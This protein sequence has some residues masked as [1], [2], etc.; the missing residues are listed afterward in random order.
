MV[1]TALCAFANPTSPYAFTATFGQ[2]LSR[3]CR[4][5]SL[6]VGVRGSS[7]SKSML[8]GHLIG[9]RCLRQN[10]DQFGLQR[11]AGLCHVV[12]LHHGLDLFAHLLV[13]HAEHRDVGDRGMGD[14]HVLG[15]LRV[16]VHAAR[17]DHVALAVGEIQ[18]TFGVEIA[19]VAERRPALVV[20]GLLRLLGIVVIGE[21]GRVG[22]INRADFARP[23][24]PRR[25]RR[26][27]SPCRP[28]RGRR[29]RGASAIAARSRP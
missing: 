2:Y 21:S 11:L 16:D 20:V 23:A 17:D 12:R 6:P 18:K 3:R 22:E 25:F 9:E 15:L 10:S 27:S 5:T 19:D 29:C 14:Q 26:G 24:F 7:G 28:R 8:F 13:R 4:L 1:G